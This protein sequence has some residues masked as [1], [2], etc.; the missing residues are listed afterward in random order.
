MFC[1]GGSA[2]FVLA[3]E[4]G[5]NMSRAAKA[6]A[7][8]L[9]MAFTGITMVNAMAE[10]K[11]ERNHP[12]RNQVNDRLENQNRRINRE[13]REGEITKGEARRLHSEDRAIRREE[14]TMSKLN[15][16]HITPAEQKALNQQE[17]A[18]SRQIGR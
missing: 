12:R 2:L 15:N 11:W 10:T 7:I 1:G 14:R 5:K 18:V 16:G 3:L 13:L 9:S 6:A 4:K 17:N 8:A